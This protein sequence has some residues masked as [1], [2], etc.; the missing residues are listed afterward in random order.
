MKGQF[1][2]ESGSAMQGSGKTIPGFEQNPEQ[3]DW[4]SGNA[5]PPL[6]PR[7]DLQL[8]PLFL[9]DSWTLGVPA[10]IKN[11]E[12]RRLGRT[13][14]AGQNRQPWEFESRGTTFF[15][16]ERAWY[17]EHFSAAQEAA[18]ARPNGSGIA[19][20]TGNECPALPWEESAAQTECRARRG[21]RQAQPKWE[22]SAVESEIRP[23]TTYSMTPRLPAAGCDRKQ[24]RRADQGR[25]PANGEPVASRPAR[26]RKRAR[27]PD[28]H[29]SD[30]RDQ[31]GL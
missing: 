31:R 28:G 14:R 27:A 15:L 18:V 7:E 30:G 24:H 23:E 12:Q 1:Q 9:E 29:R 25:L 16:Q 20:Q 6:H 2:M 26:T 5:A 21:E 11:W 3:Q 13:L 17:A 19:E 8:D 22:G 4:L 10:A